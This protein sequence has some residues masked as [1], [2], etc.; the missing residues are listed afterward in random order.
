LNT[1][2][3][4]GDSKFVG[5]LLS[6]SVNNS[7]GGGKLGA[8]LEEEKREFSTAKVKSVDENGLFFAKG[9][10]PGLFFVTV[11]GVDVSRL[12]FKDVQ[13]KIVAAN[14]KMN[15]GGTISFVFTDTPDK[16]P[17]KDLTK[18]NED[19]DDDDDDD[20]D[21]DDDDNTPSEDETV[22]E[23]NRHPNA[24]TLWATAAQGGNNPGWQC[25]ECLS[26]SPF[27]S[28]KC[29]SCEAA[30]PN[31]PPPSI[32]E[33]LQGGGFTFAAAYSTNPS[34]TTFAFGFGLTDPTKSP[35]LIMPAFGA[36]ADASAS[37]ISGG[38][39]PSPL[40]GAVAFGSGG[41]SQSFGGVSSTGPTSA[42]TI[43]S[44]ALALSFG[45]D[46]GGSVSLPTFNFAR[47]AEASQTAA[48]TA[49]T[50]FP[51]FN[52][53]RPVEA[54][55]T[56]ASTAN[57]LPSPLSV[58]STSSPPSSPSFSFGLGRGTESAQQQQQRS[59]M[60][61]ALNAILDVPTP[62]SSLPQGTATTATSSFPNFKFAR[63]AEASQT[64][65][66]T[67]TAPFPNFNFAR[68]AE[69]SRTA[70]STATAPFPNF[71]FARPAEA[72]PTA[73]STATAPFPNFN[74][75]SRCGRSSHSAS[76]CYASSH[77]RGYRLY[78]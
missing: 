66:S 32:T 78:Y 64:A 58:T 9:V 40:G 21:D 13:T 77:A 72:S 68:S 62:A 46:N 55:R 54:S 37:S 76:S 42:P 75:C 56:A 14:K 36:T 7:I 65:A 3:V 25:S 50:P 45:G 29:V 17:K 47:S 8:K 57:Q 20:N 67:A 28:P 39:S 49:T 26:K 31:A 71:K 4:Q 70:A 43:A 27:G 12:P 16:D 30:N 6:I 69:A 23:N 34:A 35:P 5:R 53:A 61:T 24:T 59:E 11:D 15:D 41:L 44:G 1:A 33:S 2:V 52:F 48:S 22:E 18:E 60:W 63:L 19:D 51:N 38:I 74:E 73:E 10:R